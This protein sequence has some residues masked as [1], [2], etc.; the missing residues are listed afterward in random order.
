[1]E[2]F[3][4]PAVPVTF[5]MFLLF[6]LRSKMAVFPFHSGALPLPMHGGTHVMGREGGGGGQTNAMH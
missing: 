3:P 1:M 6:W 5:L 4:A 2:S